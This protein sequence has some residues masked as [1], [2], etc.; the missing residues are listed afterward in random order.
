MGCITAAVDKNITVHSE[1]GRFLWRPLSSETIP[2]LGQGALEWCGAIR[3]PGGTGVSWPLKSGS[4]AAVFFRRMRIMPN[5]ASPVANGVNAAG[6]GVADGA[7]V[8][9]TSSSMKGWKESRYGKFRVSEPVPKTENWYWTYF[10]LVLV[11][12]VSGLVRKLPDIVGR[13]TAH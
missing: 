13:C 8:N 9:E 10:R 3:S 4:P 6:I 12:P 7:A 5:P 2:N 11:A 1:R